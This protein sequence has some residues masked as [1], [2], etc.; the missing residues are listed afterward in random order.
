MRIGLVRAPGPGYNGMYFS[1]SSCFS[2]LPSDATEGLVARVPSRSRPLPESRN[3]A[4]RYGGDVYTDNTRLIRLDPRSPRGT[5]SPRLGNAILFERGL[6]KD[7][8]LAYKETE[9]GRSENREK[10]LWLPDRSRA[11][12]T[13]SS[14]LPTLRAHLT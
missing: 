2:A 13:H 1:R 11:V 14:R 4:E 3:G 6:R 12:G 5:R 10:R 8:N 9:R 7:R